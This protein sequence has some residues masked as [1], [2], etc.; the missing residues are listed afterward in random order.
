MSGILVVSIKFSM[1]VYS[2]EWD[3]SLC[4][5]LSCTTAGYIFL[6][7]SVHLYCIHQE[8]SIFF[9]GKRKGVACFNNANKLNYTSLAC[10]NWT[11][12]A[13]TTVRVLDTRTVGRMQ[14]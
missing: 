10:N 1:S 3:F 6:T 8:A 14:F 7:K 2:I 13:V 11:E 5:C 4:S 9:K 12:S